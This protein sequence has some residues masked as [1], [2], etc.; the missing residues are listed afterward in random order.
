VR[1]DGGLELVA[2]DCAGSTAEG[3]PAVD[4][5]LGVITGIVLEPGGDLVFAD[6]TG[7]RVRRIEAD[8]G[9]VRTV[10]GGGTATGEG[11][12]GTAARLGRSHDQ[13]LLPGGHIAMSEQGLHA[14]WVVG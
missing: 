12:P 7:G 13:A 3:A 2:G 5:A 11:G 1:A 8:S 14:T 10:A 6:R 4:T 9:A